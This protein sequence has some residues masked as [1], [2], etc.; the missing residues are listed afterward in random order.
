VGAIG[1]VVPAGD[2]PLDASATDALRTTARSIS[3]E[4]G[5]PAWPPPAPDAVAPP[6]TA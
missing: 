3:R 4:L 2:W 6:A 1:L 5:A